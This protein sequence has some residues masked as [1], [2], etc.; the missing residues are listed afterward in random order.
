MA[1]MGPPP[2]AA[3]ERR[4]RN[5]VPGTVYLPAEGRQKKAPRF[6]LAELDVTKLRERTLWSA[7]WRTPQAVAWERFGWT[8]EVALYCRWVALAEMGSLQ[9]ATEAR[10][11]SD[12]LGLTPLALLRLRWEIVEDEVGDRRQEAKPAAD[13]RSRI[14]AVDDALAGS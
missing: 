6:P 5:A 2:K 12:R 1:G 13:V 14:R 8:V 9:A 11:L 10:Q 4:R 7:A 3:G